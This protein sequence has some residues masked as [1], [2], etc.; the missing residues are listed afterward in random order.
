[1][2]ISKLLPIIP[3]VVSGILMGCGGGGG[4][5]ANPITTGLSGTASVGAAI[6]NANVILTDV[7]GKTLTTTTD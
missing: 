6:T 3:L 2:K 7:N 5:T 1:M 4:G